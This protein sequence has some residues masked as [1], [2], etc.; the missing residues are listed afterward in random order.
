MPAAVTA[1]LNSAAKIGSI[2]P[3]TASETR[4]QTTSLRASFMAD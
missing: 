3:P 4:Q 1:M 2:G